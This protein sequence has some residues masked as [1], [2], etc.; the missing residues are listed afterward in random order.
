RY[1]GRLVS[2]VVLV[3]GEGELP[4]ADLE[5]LLRVQQGQRLD[6]AT[7]QLDL[8]TLFRVSPMAAV[9]AD[10]RTAPVLDAELDEVVEGVALTYYIYP[11]TRVS[12]VRVQGARRVP[13]RQIAG[14]ARL[15]RGD[16]FDRE[17]DREVLALRVREFLIHEGFPEASVEI[18]SYRDGDDPFS[19]EVWIRVEEGPPR[20]VRDVEVTGTPDSL[21]PRQ[22]RRWLRSAGL[23]PGKPLAEDALTRARLTVRQKLARIGADPLADAVG[24][25]TLDWLRKNGVVPDRSGGWVQAVVRVTPT[26]VTPGTFD[27]AVQITPGPRVVL[28]AEGLATNDAQ[29]ALGIDER[30]RLTRG[31]LEQ[32]DERVEKALADRGYTDAEAEVWA[33]ESDEAT[34]LHVKA[35]LGRRHRRH[36]LR[37]SG[38]DALTDSQLRTVFN[39]ASP[40]I[41]RRRRLTQE[42]L[43][44]GVQAAEFLYRSIGYGEASLSFGPPRVTRR[45]PLLTLDRSTRWVRAELQVNEG[46][47]T[48]LES[49]TVSGIAE[50]VTI[51]DLDEALDRLTGGPFSPQGLQSLAQRLAAAHRAQGFL[52]AQAYVEKQSTGPESVAARLVVVPGERVLL[53]SFAT[54]GNRRVNSPFLRRTVAPPLGAPLTSETLDGLR[55]KLYDMGMFSGLE[56]SVLGDGPARDL[57]VDVQERRRHTVEAGFGLA[58][59]Q[60]IRALG[61]WTMRNLF[62]PADRLDTNGL[63]GLRFSAGA[64]WLGVFPSFRT[65]E[66]RIGSTYTTPLSG[67]T[68]LSI[69]LVGLEQIQERNWRSLRRAVGLVHEWRPSRASRVQLGGRLEFR[70]LADADP[71]AILTNDVWTSP[72]LALP[73]DPSVDTR[74]RLVDIVDVVW[75]NDRRDNPLQPTRGVFVS[76]RAAFVP[77]LAELVRPGESAQENLRVP[78]AALEGR[79]QGALPI[80]RLSLRVSAEAGYQ[81]VLGLGSIH[82]PSASDATI[83]P[84]VPVEQRYRLGG[85]ASLRGFRRDGVGP[86]QKVRQ[87]DLDWPDGISPVVS[88]QQRVEGDRWVATGGD[89]YGKATIDLLIPLPVF[90]LTEW[91]GYELAVFSD[92]GQ[93]LLVDPDSS[94]TSSDLDAPLVRWGAGIGMRV[95]TPVGPL[96][97]DVAFNPVAIAQGPSGLLRQ[98]WNEPIA[99]LHLSLGTL[100]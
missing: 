89:A 48:R 14:A 23:V 53:R 49:I 28:A 26:E 60:G 56:L 83:R 63:V 97:A 8:R 24:P 25:R 69:S 6:L 46:P 36:A 38:N 75:V 12:A 79:T 100:F 84:A 58:S 72:R 33:D 30:L 67:Q 39:Q 73:A 99:R 70:R 43:E 52:E 22:V 93:V 55:Q 10:V 66:Y 87:L 92:V 85:T 31:F 80:G 91:E 65:P 11:A 50:I 37:F 44:R 41:I 96:Q 20:L 4:D 17:Q 78:T 90:G 51:G 54:R 2:S 9:E 16:P 13:E 76:A 86:R 94:V 7:I 32:A 45:V 40:D 5:P 1:A 27:V 77:S 59:D 71:G 47:V 62:G 64:G 95:I 3:A 34:V 88:A 42:A 81:R 57:V 68:N 74:G 29:Q 98:E 61:R 19:S 21:K 18:E 15:R 35:A 82:Q